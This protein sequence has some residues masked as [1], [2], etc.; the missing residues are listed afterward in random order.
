PLGPPARRLMTTTH[1]G[2]VLRHL[3]ELVTAKEARTV[4]D[5]QLLDRFTR[6][7]EEAAFT[8][9]VR[10]YGPLVLGVCRRVLHQEQDAEDV[11]QATFLVLA[12]KASSI[13][14]RTSL[15]SWLYRVA[16]HMA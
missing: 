7:R 16:F 12:R 9:L 2:L 8:A 5:E 10:R 13:D 6:G 14:R 15:G 11:F 1:P 3:R 4:P